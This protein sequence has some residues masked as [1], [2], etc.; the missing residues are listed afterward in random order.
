MD[1][2]RREILGMCAASTAAF[3]GTRGEPKVSLRRVPEGGIQPQVVTDQRGAIHLVYYTGGA[4]EG[5]LFYTRSSDSGVSF[6]PALAVNARSGS[7]LAA[8]TIRGAQLAIGK[9]G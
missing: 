7:A 1:F 8:G 9:E 4:H 5:N 3:A 6:A 2:T